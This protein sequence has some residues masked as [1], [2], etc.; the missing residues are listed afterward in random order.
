V[1]KN[2]NKKKNMM[3]GF[4]IFAA[5]LMLIGTGLTGIKATQITEQTATQAEPAVGD[6]CLL[7]LMGYNQINKAL[8]DPNWTPEEI[9]ILKAAR[10]AI[11]EAAKDLGCLWVRFD[12]SMPNSPLIAP[13]ASQPVA[14]TTS[15]TTSPIQ[16]SP[17]QSSS[18]SQTTCSLCAAK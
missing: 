9:D 7:L 13:M 11:L 12:Y 2:M 5:M 8:E 3:T 15:T 10:Q 4:A 1:K 14:Q 6:G 17:L 16:T 18:S